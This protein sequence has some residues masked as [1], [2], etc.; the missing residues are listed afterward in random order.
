MISHWSTQVQGFRTWTQPCGMQWDGCRNWYS[1]PMSLVITVYSRTA[2]LCASHHTTKRCFMARPLNSSLDWFW[3][4]SP[5]HQT[6]SKS[7]TDVV[8]WCLLTMNSS[9]DFKEVV[10]TV[11]TFFKTFPVGTRKHLGPR[12]FRGGIDAIGNFHGKPHTQALMEITVP[13]GPFQCHPRQ[14][15]ATVP[16]LWYRPWRFA[17]AKDMC[18]AAWWSRQQYL[19]L[20]SNAWALRIY[21]KHFF[22]GHIWNMYKWCNLHMFVPS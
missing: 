7:W 6:F 10:P 21:I 3:I 2:Y 20:L 5:R 18:Q 14:Y 9:L 1:K 12:H 8:C 4:E 17:V 16:H 15:I 22:D 11:P 19:T 13:R